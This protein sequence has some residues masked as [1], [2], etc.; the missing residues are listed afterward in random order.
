MAEPLAIKRDLILL[1]AGAVISASTSFITNL[2]SDSRAEREFTVQK[3]LDLCQDIARGIGRKMFLSL[4]LCRQM[5][6]HDSSAQTTYNEFKDD[7]EDWNSKFTSYQSLLR[8]Y[9]TDSIANEFHLHINNP[10]N[11]LGHLAAETDSSKR[12][13]DFRMMMDTLRSGEKPDL[14]KIEDLYRVLRTSN[15]EFVTKIYRMAGD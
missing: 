10:L 1:F 9:Y 7:S 13:I 2:Y 4:E 11:D 14:S 3:K 5:Y 6:Y 8:Y 12:R 15:V